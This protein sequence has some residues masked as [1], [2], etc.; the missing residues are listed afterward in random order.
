MA[1]DRNLARWVEDALKE[2]GGSA[3]IVQVCKHIWLHHR[4][5]LEAAGDL[6]YTWQYDVRWA[7]H[8]LRREGKL[9]PVDTSPK[10]V[11]QL[12]HHP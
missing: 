10:G 9:L 1:A 5:D 8:T 2:S 6:F 7:A 4:E 11:W 3:A 12:A